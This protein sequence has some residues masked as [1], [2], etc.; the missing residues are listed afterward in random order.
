V[1]ADPELPIKALSICEN[2]GDT[3]FC[4]C[5]GCRA[6][7]ASTDGKPR[8]QGDNVVL[9]ERYA[10][11]F[12]EMA[13]RVKE[14]VP[15]AWVVGYAYSW[16]Q[17]APRVV[18]LAPNVL[19]GLT[20]FSR[21]PMAPASREH[22]RRTFE[23]WARGGGRTILR[24]NAFYYFGGRSPFVVTHEMADDFRFML[25][26]GLWGT[27]FDGFPGF[28]ATSGP[29]YYVLARMHWDTGADVEALLDEYYGAF[30][31]MKPVAKEYFDFWEDRTK[32]VAHP[33]AQVFAQA[34]AILEKAGPALEKALPEEVERFRNIDFGLQHCELMLSAQRPKAG[35]EDKDKLLAA[36]KALMDLRHEMVA[37]NVTNVFSLTLSD[38]QGNRTYV[39]ELR[40]PKKAKDGTEEGAS[41][42]EEPPTSPLDAP[43]KAA[44]A[45]LPE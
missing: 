21:Y 2:D 10:R 18:E 15:D 42:S 19:M 37:R 36:A 27:D 35:E 28:W 38:L 31:P 43:G 8:M 41:P 45:E 12:N 1:E 26:R 14:V 4:T 7:D 23:G 40:Y 29:T 3:G 32:T 33:D 11:F 34:R 16:Y 13:K 9:S 44:D 17:P 25:D 39:R 22:A 24:P 30:G 5:E 6:W 20:E